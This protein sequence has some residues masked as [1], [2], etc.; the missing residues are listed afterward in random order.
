MSRLVGG[1]C[2]GGRDMV[3]RYDKIDSLSLGRVK[4]W[5]A[6]LREKRQTAIIRVRAEI[7]LLWQIPL[8]RS[9]VL[10]GRNCFPVRGGEG[11]T[12]LVLERGAIIVHVEGFLFTA[13]CLL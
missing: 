12:F 6:R 11:A 5:S 4:S 2:E 7:E 10:S 8:V 3:P 13:V 9:G 1:F